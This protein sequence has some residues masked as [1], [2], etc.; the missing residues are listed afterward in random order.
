[1]NI[2]IEQ[3]IENL[4]SAGRRYSKYERYYNGVH[5]L[6]FATEKFANALVRSFA[7]LR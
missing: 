5:E 1:M 2:N 6:S 4:R 7:S 3:A